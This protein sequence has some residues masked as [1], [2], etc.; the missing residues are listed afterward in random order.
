MKKESIDLQYLGIT[1]HTILRNLSPAKLYEHALEQGAKIAANG[2]LLVYSGEKTGRSPKDKRIVYSE[3]SKE[4]VYWGGV[5]IPM[6]EKSFYINRERALDYLNTQEHL[7]VFDG[8]AGADPEYQLKIRVIC[9]EAYHA[10][11]MNNMLIR[12]NLER[13]AEFDKPD[14]TII[15]AGSFSA[16]RYT[17]EV[18][19]KTSVVLSLEHQEMIILG[20]K[21]AGEMKKGVF[22]IVNYLMPKQNLLSMHCSANEGEN[23]EVSLFFGLSGTGKT[24]LSADVQRNLI[25]DDEH[26]WTDKGVFNVE[27]GC[28]AKCAGLSPEKEREIFS[29]I[30][31]GTVLENVIYDSDNR[32]ILFD[33]VSLTENTRAAYP[34]H[35]IEN[36]KSPAMGMHPT[37]IIFLS[38]DAYGVLPPVSLL[39]PEQAAYYFINGY[40]AKIAGTEMGITEPLA[41]FSAC[42]GEPFLV[43]A[44]RIY[45]KLLSERI[46]KHAVKIY[47]VNTGWI[48]GAYGKGKRIALE[49]SRSIIDAIHKNMLSAEESSQHPIFR[50]KIPHACPHVPSSILNPIESWEDKTAYTKQAQK[51]AKLFIDNFAKFSQDVDPSIAKAGPVLENS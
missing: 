48:G 47:L 37:N 7:Y 43:M 51:L 29:A 46:E 14:Y 35:Y 38:C 17:K 40:T 16:N 32:K 8:Y 28:Y 26:V 5:N 34:L 44:P 4:D 12:P 11:F 22:S 33:D 39:S 10:L 18:T 41:I 42:F 13:L 30:R 6:G 50:F 15:N 20:T 25:G 36:A 45:A 49:Y 23:G 27:G 1:V 21:Y 2:A 3:E 31:F 9:C 24:T 19:S